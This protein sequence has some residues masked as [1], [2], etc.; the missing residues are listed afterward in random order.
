MLNRRAFVIATVMTGPAA[1]VGC[2]GGLTGTAAPTAT[3]AAASPAARPFLLMVRMSKPEARIGQ[4]ENIVVLATFRRNGTPGPGVAG[5][6]IVAVA[7]YPGGPQTFMSPT[8]TF[9]DGRADVNIPVAPARGAT[10]VR[11]EVVA[12]YQ[13]QE[14]PAP[15][16]GFAVR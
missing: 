13:G 7:N 4:D 6:Q 12:R 11:V 5:A 8:T 2:D 10:T 16:A 14:Y 9:S 15:A 1:L 3:V